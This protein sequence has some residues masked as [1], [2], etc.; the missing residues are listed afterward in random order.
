MMSRYPSSMAASREQVNVDLDADVASILRSHAAEAHV[1]EGEIVERAIRAYDLRSL[2]ARDLAGEVADPRTPSE[3]R[4][5]TALIS[6]LV[7]VRART[8][9][10]RLEVNRRKHLV[11]S[12]P[13]HTVGSRAAE[14]LSAVR[15]RS[16]HW[17]RDYS[18]VWSTSIWPD[19]P[20][21]LM[22]TPRPPRRS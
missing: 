21:V 4:M 12:S 7:R 8:S 9:C 1:S 19:S 17:K 10:D 11:R 22:S 16:S 15:N 6:F 2:V 3:M 13:A 20:N 5:S 14:R 18:G